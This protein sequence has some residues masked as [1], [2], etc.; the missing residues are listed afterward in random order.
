MLIEYINKA[1][2]KAVYEKLEDGTYLGE[3]LSAL[4]LSPSSKL[5]R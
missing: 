3:F 2:T 4:A 1:M 5:L